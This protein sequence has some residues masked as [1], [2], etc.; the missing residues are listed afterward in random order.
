MFKLK[1]VRVDHGNNDCILITLG[2]CMEQLRHST[3]IGHRNYK[4]SWIINRK[5]IDIVLLWLSKEAPPVIKGSLDANEDIG[6]VEVSS[7]IDDVFDIGESNVES[8]EVLSEFSKFSENKESVE[9]VVV[10]GS[11]SCR[12][13]KDELNRVISA[14]KDG[15]G[16]FNSQMDEINLNLSEELANNGK[17]PEEFLCLVGLSRH[18]TLDEKTYF[19]FL[20]KD[21]EDMNIFAFIH[22]LDPT[23]VKVAERQRVEGEPRL[24]ETTVGRTA[25]LLPI[26]PDRA[27]GELE[28]SVD[29]LF[30]E[31]SGGNQTDQ[32][33]SAGGGGGEE[34][35]NIQLVIEVV[36]VAENVAPAQPRRQKKRKTLV[37]DAGGLSYPPKKLREDH[38]ILSGPFVAG[39]SRSTV[40]RLLA[41]AVLNV[42]VR[43][44]PVP[45]LPF[46]SSSVS[47]TPER[48][49]GDHT[50]FMTGLNLQTINALQRFVISSDSSRHS[51]ANI[52]EAAID[53]F[54]R[55]S[56]PVITAATTITSTVDP[57][58]AVKDKVLKPFIFSADS[59]SAGGNDPSIGG[60]TDLTGSDLLVGGIY[61]V[62]DP[63]F[64]I[65]KKRRLKSVV[66]DKDALLKGKDEEIRNLKAQLLLKEAEA[67]E[68]IRLRV[69]VSKFKAV[70]K[71]IQG[72][73]E[74]IKECNTT[75]EKE[76]NDLDVK[77]V[78][79]VASVKVREKEV[80]NLDAVVTSVKSQND[81]LVHEL[82]VS[83]AILQEKVTVYN[84]CM[85][86]K[87]YP[88]LLTAIAGHRWLLTH[89][90]E[91][92]IAKCLNSPEYLSVLGA[93]IGKAIE[94]GMQ[95][96]LAAGITHG[97]EG[98]SVNFSLLAELKLNKDSGVETLMNML[99]LEENLAERLGLNESQPHV[100]QLMVPIHHSPDQTVIGGTAL[101]LALD[102]SNIRVQNVRN[103]IAN[104]RSSLRDVFLTLAEPLSTIALEGTEGTEGTSDT[105]LDTTTALFVTFASA[106]SILPISTDDYEVV[107]V[108]GQ[109][110]AG[111]DG[112]DVANENAD[113]FLNVDFV[114]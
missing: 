105:A 83:F 71:S 29:K 18:Y 72:E 49:D 40:Q 45:I 69:K 5:K 100:D 67:A 90:M 92:V 9:E 108:D 102:V 68:A 55:P 99:C 47:A 80:A 59:T 21:E 70:E 66:E 10:G 74:A 97:W 57:A 52:A 32:G 34:G 23:K 104:H 94:K 81:N 64:D 30:D 46:V 24:L 114:S 78:D 62:I 101:S 82:E 26:A 51:G 33:D 61:T 60:F 27:E 25:P 43:V 12:L 28:A 41:R 50:D 11:E 93:D 86:E 22:T 111:A 54:A 63:E 48:E 73:V 42:E 65:H 4:R 8:M 2:G 31:G 3:I 88:Y 37:A 76:K 53:S 89:G 13:G 38:G 113:P 91:L 77:V 95:D 6:V 110:G 16:E 107:H 7:A 44:K 98:K 39:K 112:Q 56:V 19:L 103:N 96:R 85:E 87:F 109:E 14:L 1:V 20:D 58:V 17:F 84:N 79:L 35:V 15:G 75:L 106:S 36:D